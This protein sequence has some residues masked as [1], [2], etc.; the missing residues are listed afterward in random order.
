M[1]VSNVP[2]GLAGAILT[3]DLDAVVANYLLLRERAATET[4]AVVKATAY[5]LGADRVASKLWDAG[6]RI[7]FV[8]HPAEGIELRA[9]LP[10]AEIHVL[11]GLLPDTAAY[12]AHRLVPVLG[13]LAEIA[14]WRAEGSGRPCDIHVDTGMLRLGLA[15][16]EL[17]RL[18]AEPK[19][20]AGLDV[21]FV[22]S[23]FASAD[24][25]GTPQ[26]AAQ[27][28]AFQAAREVLPMGRTSFANSAGIFLGPEYRG[29]VARAGFALY[30]GNP[31]PWAPNPMR[32]R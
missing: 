14:R 10:D 18:A 13:S 29:D 11:N 24:D 23:H 4:A 30:G 27:L 32:R 26:N 21:R 28:R 25:E 22:M 12:V 8:A 31:T 9:V 2:E 19:H 1:R 20:L 16:A 3:I 17:A 7:F 15:P 5:G 6:C